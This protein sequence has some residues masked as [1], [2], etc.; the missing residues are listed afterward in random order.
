MSGEEGLSEFTHS[1]PRLSGWQLRQR[2]MSEKKRTTVTTIETHEIWIIRK[3][4]PEPPDEA[5]T[6]MP[7]EIC[8]KRAIPPFGESNNTPNKEEKEKTT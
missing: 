3:A 2:D 8:P 6:L 7:Q 5:V 4:V 1:S